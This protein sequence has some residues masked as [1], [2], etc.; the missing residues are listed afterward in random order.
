MTPE[1]EAD[2]KKIVAILTGWTVEAR[3]EVMNAIT[4]AYCPQCGQSVQPE[5]IVGCMCWNDE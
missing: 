3:V 2:V 4:H 1:M 5:Q